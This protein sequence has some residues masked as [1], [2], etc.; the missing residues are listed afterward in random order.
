MFWIIDRT[1]QIFSQAISE[2]SAQTIGW[3]ST[4]VQRAATQRNSRNGIG[5]AA[6]GKQIAAGFSAVHRAKVKLIVKYC[7]IY[8]NRVRYQVSNMCQF[9][10]YPEVNITITSN[11]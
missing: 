3:H 7:V 6:D 10:E 11:V 9:L 2:K 1:N 8:M 4:S 5:T